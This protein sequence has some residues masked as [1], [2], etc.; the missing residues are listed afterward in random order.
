MRPEPA[1]TITPQVIGKIAKAT[2]APK[3]GR[4]QP[5]AQPDPGY[6]VTQNGYGR[7]ADR[8]YVH[9]IVDKRTGE[10]AEMI[11]NAIVAAGYECAPIRN[12]NETAFS[13]VSFDVYA[14]EQA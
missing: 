13:W 4:Y 12:A 14:K 1:P 6:K 7:W 5:F 8:Q 10:W 9:V 3:A 2:G 11:R